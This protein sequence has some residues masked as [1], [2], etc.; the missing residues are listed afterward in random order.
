MRRSCQNSSALFFFHVSK[1]CAS[2]IFKLFQAFGIRNQKSV[3]AGVLLFFYRSTQMT[4]KYA[5]ADLL[6]V[7]LIQEDS[8]SV[9]L[10]FIVNAACWSRMRWK[11]TYDPSTSGSKDS[12]RLRPGSWIAF[13]TVESS[14]QLIDW[15]F[16]E[17]DQ[18]PERSWL[19]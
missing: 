13:Q 16:S 8:S 17:T 18:R 19:L 12:S 2:S 3:N 4:I 6:S 14:F 9:I 11:E 10:I 15:R 7:D 1:P 5:S